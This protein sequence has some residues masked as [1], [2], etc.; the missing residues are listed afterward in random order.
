LCEPRRLQAAL[1]AN[2]KRIGLPTKYVSGDQVTDHRIEEILFAVD[3][4][5]FDCAERHRSLFECYGG[6]GI[7]ATGINRRG[8]YLPAIGLY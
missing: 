5:M 8:D 4:N 7:D 2:T 6:I 1:R 3:N